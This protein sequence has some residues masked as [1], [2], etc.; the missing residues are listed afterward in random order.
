[1]FEVQHW[2]TA[3]SRAEYLSNVFI[4]D[5]RMPD[6]KGQFKNTFI[7]RICSSKTPLVYIGHGTTTMETRMEQHQREFADKKRKKRCTSH[8]IVAFGDAHIELIEHWPC[9]S[10]QEAKARER[11]WIER[12]NQCVNKNIPGRTREE[13]DERAQ[14]SAPLPPLPIVEQRTDLRPHQED[15]AT[16]QLVAQ[17]RKTMEAKKKRKHIDLFE[18]YRAK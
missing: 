6:P 5:V 14:A 3:F 4:V 17:A 2:Y 15:D 13:Y 12:T 16:T 1:M 9:A 11:F 18:E 10:L 7:Y 8:Q